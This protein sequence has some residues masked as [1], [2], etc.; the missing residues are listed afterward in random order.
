MF[1]QGA[2]KIQTIKLCF[3]LGGAKCWQSFI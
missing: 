2:Y 1:G 3:P